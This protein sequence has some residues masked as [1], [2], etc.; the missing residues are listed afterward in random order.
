MEGISTFC[1]A[2]DGKVAF[3]LSFDCLL[4][5]V[6]V[7]SWPQ[8]VIKLKGFNWKGEMITKGYAQLHLSAESGQKVMEAYIYTVVK[9]LQWYHRFLPFMRPDPIGLDEKDFERIICRGENRES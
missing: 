5:C 6:Y 9:D 3:S 4:S 2:K 7:Q 8:L 1:E